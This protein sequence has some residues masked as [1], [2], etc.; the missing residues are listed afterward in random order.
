MGS[1]ISI[2]SKH[3][4]YSQLHWIIGLI[5]AQS[6]HGK[7]IKPMLHWIIGLIVAQSVHGKI[8]KPM[9]QFPGK[10]F[11][12]YLQNV[13]HRTR[14]Q[15]EAKSPLRETIAIIAFSTY[16]SE[17]TPYEKEQHVRG[18]PLT[19]HS[20]A[21]TIASLYTVGFGRVVVVG[22]TMEDKED[23]VEAFRILGA[24]FRK[25]QDRNA[26][27]SPTSSYQI[28]DTELAYVRITDQSWIKTK[29]LDV[30]MP[31]GAIIGLQLALMG[32]MSDPHQEVD[33]LGTTFAASEWKYVYL[34]EPDTI[35][36]TKP[37]VLP[38]IR[39]GLD[40]GL[41]FFPHR[42]QPLPHES[43]L[44]P[45]LNDTNRNHV[46]D[47]NAG[48]FIPSHVHPFS[49]V[50]SLNPSSGRNVCCDGG[51]SWAGRSEAF[52]SCGTNWWACG[53]DEKIQQT[54]LSNAEVLER[55]KRL[56]P[57]PL[58]R[59][60]DGTGLVFGSTNQGRNC[61]PLNAKCPRSAAI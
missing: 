9:L 15:T 48:L 11:R 1:I 25:K 57:Y 23:V 10:I 58:M 18:K 14:E 53:F 22:H 50:K 40:R 60:Q 26:T 21:A 37:W 8:I 46:S 3:R 16:R 24:V 35:L 59:L 5:V 45:S 54:K 52:G 13:A 41:S 42:M 2:Y 19:A 31:R 44:P 56:V 30:N 12:T 38:S 29:A 20:L 28:G 4:S 36:H 27:S 39:D 47:F 43:D 17:Y 7:I 34:T 33:W 32:R 6:V 61:V 49:E 51:K 55:H